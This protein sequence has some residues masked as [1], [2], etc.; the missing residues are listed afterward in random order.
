MTGGC[1]FSVAL[2]RVAYIYT[3]VELNSNVFAEA[4]S[5]HSKPR[6][7]R[8]SIVPRVVDQFMKILCC[9]GSEI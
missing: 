3:L 2:Y 7:F 9:L 6:G 5:W 1:G 4:V 8:F